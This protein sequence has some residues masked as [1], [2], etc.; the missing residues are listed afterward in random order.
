MTRRR[1]SQWTRA[2]ATDLRA[3]EHPGTI[4]RG[5]PQK[6]QVTHIGQK[7]NESEAVWG[8]KEGGGKYTMITTA[9]QNK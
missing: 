4:T 9:R 6:E 2:Y 3:G 1:C 8:K 5:I 7:N